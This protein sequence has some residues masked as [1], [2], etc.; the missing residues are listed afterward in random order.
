[1]TLTPR[2]VSPF[3]Q[4]SAS[5]RVAQVADLSLAALPFVLGLY[6]V[7]VGLPLGVTSGRQP[8]QIGRP[9]R[10]SSVGMVAIFKKRA[11]PAW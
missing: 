9:A 10:E 3:A 8:T 6:G 2:P 11:P 1:M 7:L 4:D 5:L